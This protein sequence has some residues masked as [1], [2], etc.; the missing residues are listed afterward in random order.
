MGWLYGV[1]TMLGIL[2][3]DQQLQYLNLLNIAL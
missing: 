2:E 3:V 1:R